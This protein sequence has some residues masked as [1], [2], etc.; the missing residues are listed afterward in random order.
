MSNKC[1]APPE[2]TDHFRQKG[3]RM[4]SRQEAEEYFNRIPDGHANAIQRPWDK[5]TDRSLRRMIEKANC[6]G[7][8]IV[9]IGD[10]IFRP[11][12]GD[13]VDEAALNKYLNKEL[14]RAR[15]IQLKRLCMKQT[16]EG[17]RNCAT[18]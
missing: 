4:G 15:S 17:W 9:N 14:S 3:E 13:K 11:I 10:G 18:P 1:I 8:C 6:N 2:D 16:F 12:P 5:L 7:D